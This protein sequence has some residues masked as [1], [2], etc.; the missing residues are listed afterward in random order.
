MLDVTH[1]IDK[2]H[3]AKYVFEAEDCMSFRQTILL[4]LAFVPIFSW[5][6]P[7]RCQSECEEVACSDF[8]EHACNDEACF[9]EPVP[10]EEEPCCPDGCQSCYA[11]C[12]SSF[13]FVLNQLDQP[14][15]APSSV[16][17]LTQLSGSKVW[18]LTSDI[19][20]PPQQ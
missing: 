17:P 13:Y 5:A 14:W 11:R 4:V 9:E 10:S 15:L 6:A 16:D 12:C 3:T 8:V 1:G 20:K 2:P 19:F 7:E 18:T